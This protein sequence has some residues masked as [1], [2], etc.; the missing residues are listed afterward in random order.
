[1]LVETLSTG[2]EIRSGAVIDTNAAHIAQ[3]LEEM[4]IAV[5]RHSC[6]GD[7]KKILTKVIKEMS[8]RADTVIVTGGL[9]PTVDDITAQAA[10]DATEVELVLDE[11]ALQMIEE[12]FKVRNR[13]LSP[14]NKKQALLPRGA[15]CLYNPVGTAPG[16][17]LKINRCFFYM[18]PGVPFEM[19]RMLSDAI[20]PRILKRNGQDRIYYR[21]KNISTFGLPESEVNER[22]LGFNE[23]FSG[24]TLGLR[25]I[26]PEIH[27]KI[28]G[29][30]DNE[31]NLNRQM[32]DGTGWI[33]NRI[34]INL[35]SPDGNSMEA[36]VGDLL[37]QEKATLAVAESCTGGLISN[38]LT[39]VPGSSA[40]LLFSGIT[41]SN[42]SKI[43]VLGVS[44]DTLAEYGAV[45]EETA[46]QM[47]KGIREVAGATYGISTTGIAGPDG[48]TP[49]K[50]VGTV[51]IGIATPHTAKGV[52][53]N[54]PFGQRLRNKEIFAVMAMDVLRRELIAK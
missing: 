45:N 8:Q 31:N 16:F 51:C 28:Y 40:Y 14:S 22:L 36:V 54:L 43:N 25:A 32:M 47:A 11:K 48:G 12:F 3:Q 13:P 20:L 7:D 34:G 44:P 29:K 17:V 27:V 42:E 21:V 18:M 1:M 24:L 6:V 38:R 46:K 39:N 52:R 2:D 37:C 33:I 15:E 26:F 23:T 53:F 49:E 19:R 30:G 50:P 10:A 5:V 41:Y 35:L 4:G 9:G